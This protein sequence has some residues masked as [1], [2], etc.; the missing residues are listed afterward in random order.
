MIRLT[1]PDLAGSIEDLKSVLGTGFLVQGKTVER[2][3][4]LVADY[5]GRKHA[6]AVSSGTSA[7]H[8]AL[9]AAG[10]GEGDEV[11]VPDFTFPATANAVVN[12]GAV[13]VLADIDPDA[14]SGCGTCVEW[15]PTEAVRL[16]EED[17]A[18][19]DESA[20]FGCGVCARFCP[21]SAIS[22]QEGLRRVFILP[23]RLRGK[24]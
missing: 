10:I 3:E 7:I 9:M 16:D 14:C 22:L 17:L 21:E 6:V 13:P 5:V 15:C 4:S 23:P 1:S 24:G 18:I 20:C 19:R 8:C 11:I 12:A 2:F